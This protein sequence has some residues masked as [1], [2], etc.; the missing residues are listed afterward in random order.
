MLCQTSFTFLKKWYSI[1]SYIRFSTRI[2][3]DI[4]A[5]V[6]CSNRENQ[7]ISAHLQQLHEDSEHS[8]HTC[9][10][11]VK[12]TSNLLVSLHVSAGTGWRFGLV[13]MRWP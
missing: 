12:T 4:I 9:I 8:Q 11:L 2:V 13:A 3:T 6:M 7:R 1:E 5:N 10:Q